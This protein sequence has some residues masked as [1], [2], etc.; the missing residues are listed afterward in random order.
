[1]G[2]AQTRTHKRL[3]G[4]TTRRVARKSEIPVLVVASWLKKFEEAPNFELQ[5]I[6]LPIRSTSKDI[7]ALRLA[8]ALKTSSAAKDAEL[9]ALNL[10]SFPEVK[11]STPLGA[12]EIKLQ[13]ELFMDD[14]SIFSK[15]SGLEITPKHLAAQKIG[16]AAIEFAEKE[17]VDLILLGAHRKPRRFGGFLGSVSYEIALKT[18]AAVVVAFTP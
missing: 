7:A 15:Q 14:V 5:K 8:A 4:S 11:T 12:P 18:H 1:M 13:R 2:A 17:K 6:L 3:L 16:E 9:V 10:T